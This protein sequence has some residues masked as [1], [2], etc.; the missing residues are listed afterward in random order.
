MININKLKILHENIKHE[1]NWIGRQEEVITLEIENEI[2][3]IEDQIE[4]KFHELELLLRKKNKRIECISVELEDAKDRKEEEEE[5]QIKEA[6][7]EERQL[8]Q[9]RNCI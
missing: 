1:I 2:E 8:K 7:E 4:E 6:E 5:R 9:E 3:E